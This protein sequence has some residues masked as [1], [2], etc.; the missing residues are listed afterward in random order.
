MKLV[1]DIVSGS[2]PYLCHIMTVITQYK[3]ALERAPRGPF[4]NAFYTKSET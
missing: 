3:R 1:F 2:G 4:L